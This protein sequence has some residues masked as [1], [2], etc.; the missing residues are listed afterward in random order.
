MIAIPMNVLPFTLKNEYEYE[1]IVFDEFLG[2]FEL[3]GAKKVTDL[4]I[5]LDRKS[6]HL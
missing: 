1:R 5:D 6:G 2:R 4:A 3:N